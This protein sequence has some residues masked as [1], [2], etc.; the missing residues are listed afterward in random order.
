MKDEILD[1]PI[2]DPHYDSYQTFFDGEWA[3]A[4]LQRAEN[5]RLKQAVVDFVLSCRYASEAHRLPWLSVQ[6]VRSY[7]DGEA[8]GSL[9]FRS[10]YAPRLINDI[11]QKIA[12]KMERHLTRNIL[13]ALRSAVKEIEK[14][15]LIG[16]QAAARVKFNTAAYW[17]YMTDPK[18]DETGGIPMSIFGIQRNN[19][20]ALYFAYEDLSLHVIRTKK[21]N[22]EAKPPK[23]TIGGAFDDH[24]GGMLG[25]ECWDDEIDLARLV[26][27]QL[28]HSGGR[29]DAKLE[30][31]HKGRF[32]FVEPKSA[33]GPVL[34]GDSFIVINNRIQITA[35]NG[36]HLY[37]VLKDRAMK[38]I[39]KAA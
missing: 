28:V 34:K 27:N 12:K 32:V 35:C 29:Y 38:M 23:V 6:L 37:D 25:K 1:T 4:I 7:A 36:R 24:F 19:Y 16:Q 11:V 22:F 3:R 20:L 2:L 15:A 30:K 18:R 21:P 13:K 39:D 26:R 5:S 10:R 31:K 9:T 8:K 14:D 33:L 17:H